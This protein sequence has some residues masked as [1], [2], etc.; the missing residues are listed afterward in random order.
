[1]DKK[2]VCSKC[3]EN[4]GIK[5]I[6]KS[7]KENQGPCCFCS[8]AGKRL[9]IEAVILH[10]QKCIQREYETRNPGTYNIKDILERVDFQSCEGVHTYIAKQLQGPSYCLRTETDCISSPLEIQ[11]LQKHWDT[12]E[13]LIKEKCR[14][15]MSEREVDY[16]ALGGKYKPYDFLKVFCD[17]MRAADFP[18]KT[19]KASDRMFRARHF[20]GPYTAEHMGPPPT[21]STIP[22]RLTP[23]GISAF[24]A[25]S[26][27]QTAINEVIDEGTTTA[28]VGIWQLNVPVRV[29][30]FRRQ[31][32]GVGPDF[33]HA[34]E[35]QT[36]KRKLIRF[37]KSFCDMLSRPIDKC[38]KK[39][40]LDYVP[41]QALAEYI[42]FSFSD[43]RGLIY[44]SSKSSDGYNICLFSDRIN[45][46][47][48]HDKSSPA[49]VVSCQLRE[50][51]PWR[52]SSRG[53]L[54]WALSKKCRKF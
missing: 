1:M 49:G 10:I 40:H 9:P 35:Q 36:S 2:Y 7:S 16:N 25:A 18:F 24:Y 19:I 29:V 52:A 11:P 42:K 50:H 43:V 44:D 6:I 28:E 53:C 33:F 4:Q 39:E 20:R 41:A 47:D 22:T 26:N 31:E 23:L 54:G 21:G 8:S 37:L 48:S 45:F 46:V 38:D 27:E 34:S 17:S 3:F 15:S 51:Y 14:F 32:E 12:F 13:E 30:D 5:D